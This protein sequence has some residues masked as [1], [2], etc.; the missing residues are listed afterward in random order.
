MFC[1]LKFLIRIFRLFT[2][3]FFNISIIALNILKILG[4][5]SAFVLSSYYEYA[6]GILWLRVWRWLPFPTTWTAQNPYRLQ[7]ITQ[8]YG[9]SCLVY[10]CWYG[11]LLLSRL[12]YPSIFLNSL[13]L[14]FHINLYEVFSLWWV[15]GVSLYHSQ[16][17]CVWNFS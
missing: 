6:E 10:L 1:L 15:Y 9:V 3:K 2:F 12:P 4:I 16:N 13:N 14:I 11:S 17:F 5:V 7:F 8:T